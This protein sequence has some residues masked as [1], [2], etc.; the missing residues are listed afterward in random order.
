MQQGVRA[1]VW[2]GTSSECFVNW[3]HCWAQCSETI[4]V[5]NVDKERSLLGSAA[6]A[7]NI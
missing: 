2:L 1:K 4:E 6:S 5:K 7:I 3:L